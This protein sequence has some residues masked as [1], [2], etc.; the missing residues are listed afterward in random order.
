M[1]IYPSVHHN[2]LVNK[3]MLVLMIST[4]SYDSITYYHGL[5]HLLPVK[6]GSRDLRAN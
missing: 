2:I 1:V 4:C 3:T 6:F 5:S